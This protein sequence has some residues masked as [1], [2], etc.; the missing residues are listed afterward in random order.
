MMIEIGNKQDF[1]DSDNVRG[2]GTMKL[3]L[4]QAPLDSILL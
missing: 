3:A 4:L 2:K 1:I